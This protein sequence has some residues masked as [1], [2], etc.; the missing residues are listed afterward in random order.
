MAVELQELYEE[1]L[2]S[3]PQ[4]KFIALDDWTEA[5]AK[6]NYVS[7]WPTGYK[8][9]T[10]VIRANSSWESSSDTT[11]WFDSGCGFVFGEQDKYNFHLIYLGLDGN[12]HYS[13]WVDNNGEVIAEDH[14]GEVGIPDG[15]ADILLAVDGRNFSFYIKGEPV[16]N[17]SDT[18]LNPGALSFTIMSGTN[19]GFGTRCTD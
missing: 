14:Y 2:I 6:I 5:V 12:V 3:S 15:S 4:G 9:D 17:S 18:W 7:L 13:R 8:P 11:N 16:I 1:G 10:F 19:K